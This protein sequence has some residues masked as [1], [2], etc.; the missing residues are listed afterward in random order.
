MGRPGVVI[1]LNEDGRSGDSGTWEIC[2]AYGAFQR[3]RWESG[4][5]IPGFLSPG[6]NKLPFL[7]HSRTP[8]GL[9]MAVLRGQ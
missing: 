9:T 8:H 3:R 6:Q 5:E 2:V 4:R 1:C 7:T